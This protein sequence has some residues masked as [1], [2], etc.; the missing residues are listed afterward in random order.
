MPPNER[1]IH[2][3]RWLCKLPDVTDIQFKLQD[4]VGGRVCKSIYIEPR[5]IWFLS[6]PPPV[7]EI[8]NTA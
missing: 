4:G 5:H 6:H 7:L 1:E 8:N 3:W 2:A